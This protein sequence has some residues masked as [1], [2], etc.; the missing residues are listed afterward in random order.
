[1]L[2]RLQLWA[3]N[4]HDLLV[5]HINR[6]PRGF[7]LLEVVVASIIFVTALVLLGGL[8][9]S[10]HSALS[11]SR[12]RLIANGLA[13]AVMEQ[14]MAGGHGSLDPI[15]DA[16]QVQNFTSQAQVRGRRSN[17]NFE[18][19]FLATDPGGP[20]SSLR[21]M[22]VTVTWEEDSGQKSLTYESCLSKTQ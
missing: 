11:Q 19:T 17:L 15:I 9:V 16:P 22:T 13:R 8:W 7:S 1:M 14:R 20:N 3:T 6:R 12:N 21:R 4:V 2:S 18:A 5:S 10:Y